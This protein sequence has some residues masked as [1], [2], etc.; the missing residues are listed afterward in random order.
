MAIHQDTIDFYDAIADY[1][2]LLY[3]DWE[4]QLEREGLGLR[5][6]FRNRGIVQVLDAACGVGTQAIPMAQLGFEVTACDPSPRM[7]EKARKLAEQYDVAQAVTFHQA[8]FETLTAVVTGPFDAIVCKGNALPHLITDEEIETTLLT[9]YELLR[10]G[11]LLVVGM[12]DFDQMRAH[13]PNFL[14]GLSHIEEENEFITYEIWEWRDGP[15][16]VATQNLYI[17]HGHPNALKTI[18][19]T[20]SF[21][22]LSIEEVRVVLSELGYEEVSEQPDRWEQV[23]VA[24]RPLGS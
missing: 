4:V 14:P 23:L 24:R 1:Y 9:F 2:P 22:P 8:D 21:R 11:G 6:L 13:R 10:P 17:T 5:A 20:T 3:K 12:R 18:K 16:M 19:R 15:P 7:L